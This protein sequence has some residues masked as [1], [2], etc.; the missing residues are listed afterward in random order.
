MQITFDREK[1]L[2]AVKSLKNITIGKSFMPVIN[3][4][5]FDIASNRALLTANNLEIEA[6]TG[7][8]CNCEAPGPGTFLLHGLTLYEVLSNMKGIEI[9]MDIP[10]V[11]EYADKTSP[12][13]MVV[14]RKSKTKIELP[15]A[16]PEDFPESK[17]IEGNDIFTLPA[18]EFQRGVIR[19]F[20]AAASDDTRYVLTGMM[21]EMKQGTFHM[22]ATDGFRIAVSKRRV[23][24]GGTQKGIVVPAGAMKYMK[25]VFDEHAT[26]DI[27]LEEKRA[28]FDTGKIA[29]TSRVIAER[30]PDYESLFS[31]GSAGLAI[32]KRVDL[33]ESL[34]IMKA[35]SKK[36]DVITIRRAGGLMLS[37]ETVAG[38]A[39]DVIECKYRDDTP[40]AL[41]FNLKYVLEAVEHLSGEEIILQYSRTYGM[42]RIDEGT[43][44][45]PDYIVGIMPIRTDVPPLDSTTGQH[46]STIQI[47]RG[48]A[49]KVQGG[50]EACEA[51]NL[52]DAGL[53]PE[54]SGRES[55]PAPATKKEY[56][57]KSQKAK[58]G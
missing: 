52:D 57:V 44:D 3:Y 36:D 13:S 38:N 28:R 12:L 58:A 49:V 32:I 33:L 45:T 43:G 55:N 4:I 34:K 11:V 56:K 48:D 15:L 7:V 31:Q 47:P 2:T 23:A 53:V 20:Y 27:C 46:D 14:I 22:V 6:V 40:L 54:S 29:V 5:K 51:H 10:V 24:E 26:I 25:D 17:P 35:L 42:I 18:G 1:L 19:T 39:A 30:Y 9:I 50:E 21:M 37:V 16:D 41:N 8:P